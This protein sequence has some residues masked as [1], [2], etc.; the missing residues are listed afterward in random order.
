MSSWILLT[1]MIS[2][3]YSTISHIL[4][5]EKGY[6][7]VTDKRGCSFLMKS[8]VLKSRGGDLDGSTFYFLSIELCNN[9]V[10]E[11]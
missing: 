2:T 5:G 9:N 8:S 11:Y 1:W 7:S 6:T 4:P 3:L 10:G